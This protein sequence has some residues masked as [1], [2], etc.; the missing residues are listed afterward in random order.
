MRKIKLS[1]VLGVTLVEMLLVLT[2]A[3][4]AIYASVGYI[5]SRTQAISI[6]RA[7]GQIQQILNAGL[8]YY[9]TNQAW[10][11]DV[12][13]LQTGGY[14]PSGT[15]VGPW[16]Y[17]YTLSTNASGSLLTVSMKFPNN[18]SNHA[19]VS[20]IL[21]GRL[22]MASSTTNVTPPCP[23]CIPPVAGSSV[24]SISASVGV[25]GQSLNN[26][27]AVNFTGIY[28]N[29]ACVPVPK[30]PKLPDGTAMVPTISVS[31]ASVS[32]M[33]DD[34]NTAYP[35]SSFT[36]Y[37]TGPNNWTKGGS[38]GPPACTSSGFFSPVTCD[39]NAND[40]RLV[41]TGQYWRVCLQVHTQKGSVTWNATTAEY[42]TVLAITRCSVPTENSGSSMGVWR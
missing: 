9:V 39:L 10:P 34:P 2:I 35:I 17:G 18:M 16:G 31:P 11:T 40:D 36:A 13:Q 12:T 41:A 29:A 24:S 26:A 22:P 23:S 21:A 19:A 4:A 5:Q 14:L 30:C 38:A 15:I 37:A 1:S 28:H 42:A 7:A 3:S 32:G 8:S 27:T 33:N 20:K 25:P 6:D